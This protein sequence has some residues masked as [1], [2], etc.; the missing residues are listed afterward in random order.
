MQQHREKMLEAKECPRPPG[1][2]REACNSVPSPRPK[3]QP[4]QHLNLGLLASRAVQE[5]FLVF[6]TPRLGNAVTE[7]AWDIHSHFFREFGECHVSTSPLPMTFVHQ[8]LT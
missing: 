4:C 7:M 6:Q 8:F 3:N 1:D 2:G 5:K